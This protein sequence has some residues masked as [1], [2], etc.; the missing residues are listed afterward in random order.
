M[1]NV[2][3]N[4]NLALL[5]S[6]WLQNFY[7]P[8]RQECATLPNNRVVA[9]RRLVYLK[10]KFERDAE[11]FDLYKEKI[12]ELHS[13]LTSRRCSIKYESIPRIGTL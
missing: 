2:E 4:R 7:L 6:T 12:K 10:R 3:K 1:Q 11:F 9:E 13:Q 8:W 5:R